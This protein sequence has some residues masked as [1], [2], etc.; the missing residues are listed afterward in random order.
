MQSL[1]IWTRNTGTALAVATLAC[2][3]GCSSSNGPKLIATSVTIAASAST[4]NAGAPVTLTSTVTSS[5]ATVNGGVIIYYDGSVEVSAAVIQTGATGS[6]TVSSLAPGVHT[7]TAYYYGDT[8]HAPSTSSPTTVTIYVP[9]TIVLTPTPS[10]APIGGSITLTAVI[11]GGAYPPT[12]SIVFT[13]GGVTLGTAAI[14]TVNTK[15][16]ASITTTALPLGNDVVT[17]SY[18]ANGYFLASTG[19]TTVDINNGPIPTT[20]VVTN[21][22]SGSVASGTPVT[23]TAAITPV[24]AGGVAITGTVQFFDRNASLGSV[25]VTGTTSSGTAALVTRQFNVGANAITAVYSGDPNFAPS[26]SAASTVT[27]LAYTGATYTNPLSVND[28][29]TGKVYNCPDPAVI[30]SQSGTTDTWYAYCTGDAFNV[31]DAATPGGPLR[32]HLI[33]IFSSPDLVNWTYVRDAFPTLPSWIA[34]NVQ[35][36][37]PAI[38]YFNNLYHLYYTAPAVAAAP[39]G[40]A[41]GVGTSTTPGGPFTDHGTYVVEPQIACGGGCN[42]TVIAPEVIADGTGQLWITYGGVLAGIS[43]RQLSADGFSSTP[44]SEVGIGIDN[45]YQDPFILFENGYF[46]EFGTTGNCCGGSQSTFNVHVGRSTNVTGPYLDA[47]GNDMNAFAP[48]G[49]PSLMWNGNDIIGSGSNVVITD[50]SGQDYFVYSGVSKTTP[51]IPT[52]ICYT[53]RQLMM[54]PLDWVNGWPVTR[55]GFGPSDVSTPQPVPAAQPGATNG[56]APPFYTA[57]QPG[58]AIAASSDDF[59]ETTLSSQWT[60]LHAT[61]SYTLN[62]STFTIPSSGAESSINMASLPIL[63]EPEPTGSY[64][65]EVKESFDVPATG[66][67]GFNYAQ[68]GMFLYSTDTNYLRLDEYADYDTRQIEFA[69]QFSQGDIAFSL[70]GT[71][72]FAASTWLRLVKHAGAGAGGT[73]LFTSYS[74]VDG[75]T[76]I[77][78]DTWTA[79][80]GSGAKIGLFSGNQSGHNASFDYIHVSTLQ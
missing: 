4:A 65:I 50:E 12:G 54:D 72:D 58:T 26:T 56:Y 68:A 60:F 30:K 78:G 59:N 11:S 16:T 61:P 62:G 52:V 67:C 46:Y 64:V 70:G 53:A 38:K 20:T 10:F 13:S 51:C 22:A 49:D 71:P 18:A 39:N 9:T 47:E 32:V 14:A 69:N 79:S 28:P 48:G 44:S 42:R 2:L 23:L 43:I 8:T 74:S 34:A 27:L 15:Q 3:A 41:I 6:L 21:S 36:Q 31:N 37:T 33:S 63:A 17:A 73:D 5:G 19:T 45:Y 29:A 77:K 25:A 55:G 1:G 40:S 76:F 66:C 80:Y 75:V 24:A 7:L 35:L 57:D